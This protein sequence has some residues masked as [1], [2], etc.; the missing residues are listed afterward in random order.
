MTA[1]QELIKAL[2]M[3]VDAFK[4]LNYTDEDIHALVNLITQSHIQA[5]GSF[6][7][8]YKRLAKQAESEKKNPAFQ[9]ITSYN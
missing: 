6:T 2:K 7:A 4:G 9:I 3:I 5:D 8:E 1:D